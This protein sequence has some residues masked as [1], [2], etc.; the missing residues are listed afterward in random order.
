M[1]KLFRIL[2]IF[3][4]A[5]SCQDNSIENQHKFKTLMIRSQGEVETLSD[6]ATFNISL[7]CLDKSIEQSKNCLVKKSNELS[8][9][10][11][12]L[13]IDQDDILQN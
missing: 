4:L 12:S 3:L 6:M 8:E 2:S 7:S 10:L 11:I 1:K 9:E 13:G 5:I